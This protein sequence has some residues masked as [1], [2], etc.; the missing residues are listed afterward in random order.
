[1]SNP[2][3]F[4]YFQTFCCI[5]GYFNNSDFA[6]V[7]DINREYRKQ[8][9]QQLKDSQQLYRR[10]ADDAYSVTPVTSVSVTGNAN[11]VNNSRNSSRNNSGNFLISPRENNNS[12]A[13][14]DLSMASPGVPMN[15]KNAS[16]NTRSTASM[17]VSTNSQT[18]LQSST[19]GSNG[20]INTATTTSTV[21]AS[22]GR[23]SSIHMLSPRGNILFLLFALLFIQCSS[24]L[25]FFYI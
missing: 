16:M 10:G 8:Q 24:F 2:I 20:N 13:V 7:S 4:F 17:N 12:N 1:M 22:N 25:F 11:S 9:Q 3:S 23:R 19:G 5:C 18:S 21:A 15:R 14:I 6:S